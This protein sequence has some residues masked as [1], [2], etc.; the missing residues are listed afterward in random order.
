MNVVIT[1][2]GIGSRL[3]DLTKHTNKCLVRVDDKPAISH[4]IESYPND[5]NFVITLGHYGD[6]V[7]Q[8]LS[9]A[10]PDKKITFVE[11]DVYEGEGSSLGY[12]IYKCKDKIN[13]PFIY[14][15][16]DSIIK[17]LKIYNNNFI[18]G[19]K[20]DNVSQYR[21]L[22]NS[23]S[24]IYDK[25]EIE[26]DLAYCGICGVKDYKKFFNLL[27]NYLNKNFADLTEVDVLN[28]M[29]SE[30]KFDVVE[31]N[32]WFDI[33]NNG[34][35]HSTRKHFH[36]KYHVLDKPE[37]SIY[38]FDDFVIK[39][40]SNPIIVKNRVQRAKDME[41]IVPKIV[42]HTENF[43]KYKIVESN[44]YASVISTENFEKLLSWSKDDLWKNVEF[45]NFNSLCLDFYYHK[46]IERINKFC[47]HFPDDSIYINDLKIPKVSDL[48]KEIDFEYLANGI[49]VRFHGDFILDNILFDGNKFKLIDWRQD[50]QGTVECGDIYYDLAKLNH[51]LTL[52]HRVLDSQLF[53]ID[54]VGKDQIKL[55]ILVPFMN[56]Q[57]QKQYHKWIVDNNF[58]LKKIKI[59][60]CL[61]WLNMSP[62][63]EY[64]LSNFLFN[65]GKY[66]L[67]MN[68][69]GMDD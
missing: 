22:R 43:Y 12:S 16:C 63:H 23:S 56:K 9:L 28:I 47:V 1:T 21:T 34:E 48:L 59:L 57:C 27:G 20:K 3:G 58:D 7:K 69:R 54:Y 19:S 68:L 31:V 33:G 14:H 55:D 38:F 52:N 39:F 45:E 24:R 6:H 50:F 37:E 26:Y 64:P 42:A 67:F 53:N 60:T 2:S 40:F 62:L 30:S 13:G 4:I 46:T 49:P 29:S 51:S 25:G 35:L 66:N 10:Y 44:L 36:S 5:T 32:E 8:F 18:I 65:F 15:A 11:V 17:D 41:D 61:I